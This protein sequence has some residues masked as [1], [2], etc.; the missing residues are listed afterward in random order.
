MLLRDIY[1]RLDGNTGKRSLKYEKQEVI[2][3]GVKGGIYGC[4]EGVYLVVRC[5]QYSNETAGA[6][7]MALS[8]SF[9]S[10]IRSQYFRISPT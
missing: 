9:I 3:V 6:R 10:T 1:T 2:K 5:F 7:E 4:L 8:Y